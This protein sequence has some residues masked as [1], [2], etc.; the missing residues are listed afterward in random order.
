MVAGHDPQLETA[1]AVVMKLLEDQPPVRPATPA[2][3]D[4]SPGAN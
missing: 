4:R 1:V 3:P 2:Y